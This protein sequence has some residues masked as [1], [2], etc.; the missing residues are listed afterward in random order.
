[1]AAIHIYRKD[2]TVQVIPEEAVR[3][4][5]YLP[6][7]GVVRVHFV[8]GDGALEVKMPE[9]K[10]RLALEGFATGYRATLREEE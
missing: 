5:E 4:V 8:H 9:G 2:G 7:L 6:A 3:M 1:M 10:A